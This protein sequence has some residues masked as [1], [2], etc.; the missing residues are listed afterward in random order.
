[1]STPNSFIFTPDDTF[2]DD[3]VTMLMSLSS[4]LFTIQATALSYNPKEFHERSLQEWLSYIQPLKDRTHY[5]SLDVQSSRQQILFFPF[6][7]FNP[8]ALNNWPQWFECKLVDQLQD[9]SAFRI[10]ST[11]N[12]RI[13]SRLVGASFISYYE[14]Q[15]DTI[16][17]RYS[18]KYQ[19]W[20]VPLGFARHI[21]NGFAHNGAFEVRSP[22]DPPVTWKNWQIDYN[23]NG[24]QVL[25]TSDSVGIG[26]LILLMQ[27]MNQLVK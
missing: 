22:N 13:L 21:R 3:L 15:K 25:F 12:S 23:S 7:L 10:T 27:E 20:P 19:N 2:Y 6:W 11:Q 5:L 14:S 4:Y 9:H 8:I 18:K 16:E 17:T 24:K 26:D 1:M